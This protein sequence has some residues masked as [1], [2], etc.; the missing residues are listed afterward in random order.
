MK[1]WPEIPFIDVLLWI[2]RQYSSKDTAF[3]FY[4]AQALWRNRNNVVYG[5]HD[6]D[7]T[8][9]I[10]LD[11][12]LRDKFAQFNKKD[13]GHQKWSVAAGGNFKINVDGAFDERK[14]MMG[15]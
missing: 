13:L 9:F 6:R 2:R 7:P 1:V 5:K 4:M 3:F 10:K 12:M 15:I 8:T 11:Q 14:G